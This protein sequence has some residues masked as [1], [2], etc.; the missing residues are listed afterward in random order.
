MGLMPEN[1]SG[2]QKV[3]LGVAALVLIFAGY[4]IYSNLFPSTP[5][6]PP[7]QNT[8]SAGNPAPPPT[9]PPAGNRRKVG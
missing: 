9:P 1:M 3:T 8:D 2:K 5:A 7:V 4:L 6:P